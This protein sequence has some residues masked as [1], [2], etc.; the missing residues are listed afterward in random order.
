MIKLLKMYGEIEGDYTKE[1]QEWIKDITEEEIETF[2]K[3][4]F[5]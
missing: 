5:N 3:E 2:I 4:N 1:R